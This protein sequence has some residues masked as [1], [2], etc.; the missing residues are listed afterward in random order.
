MP[1]RRVSPAADQAC[2]A[3]PWRKANQ[4]RP[5]PHNWYS[6]RNLKRLWSALRSGGRMTCHPTDPENAVPAGERP[7]PRHVRTREC[8]GALILVQR[9][10]MRFQA[11]LRDGEDLAACYERYR[12]ANPNGLSLNGLRTL[13]ARTVFAGTPGVLRMTR[14]G[15]NDPAVGYRKLTPWVRDESRPPAGNDP[16]GGASARERGAARHDRKG[17][18]EC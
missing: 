16:A 18:D 13:V 12:N 9:E 2:L 4:G 11:A 15:L 17:S 3:C 5:H 10:F 1:E 6:G 14:P 8:A 7:A